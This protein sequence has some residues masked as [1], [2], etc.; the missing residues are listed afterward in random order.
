[1][2]VGIADDLELNFLPP[3]QAL[4]HQDLLGEG[5]SA[6]GQ[7]HERLLVGTDAAAL[8]AEGVGRT[9]HDGETYLVGGLQRIAHRLHGMALG[10]LHGDFVQLLDEEVAVLRVHDGFHG[11]AQHLDAILLQDAFLI[12]FRATVQG[13]LPA[14]GQQ[15]AVGTLLLD[16]TLHEVRSNGEE[17]HLVG[18]AFRG[19]NRCDVGVDQ[20]GA[21]E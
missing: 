13:R 17:I 5:E 9:D 18:N 20:H 7:L 16:D 15:D 3:L 8:S 19:L 21:D 12:Q 6:L 14:K 1:M 11:S 4:L 2:V 10:G